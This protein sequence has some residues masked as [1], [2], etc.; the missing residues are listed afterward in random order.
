MLLILLLVFVL[1][2]PAS[3]EA[4]YTVYLKNGSTISGVSSYEK[5]DGEV[6][7]FFGGGSMGISVDEILKIQETETP[8]KD[9]RSKE[10]PSAEGTAPPV[11]PPPRET[12]DKSARVNVLKTALDDVNADLSNIEEEETKLLKAISDR[13]SARLSYNTLQLRKLESDLAPLQQQLYQ[14]Q[15]KKG[16]LMQKRAT[17]D[18]ELK[19]LQ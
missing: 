12:V 5:R 6:E 18:A 7:I 11:A 4:S 17:I 16:V 8:E 1:L 3:S 2:L 19:A 10:P 14:L 9:F 13:K 15:V